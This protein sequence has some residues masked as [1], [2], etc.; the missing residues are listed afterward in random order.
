MNASASGECENLTMPAS[1]PYIKLRWY[2]MHGEANF[3][4]HFVKYKVEGNNRNANANTSVQ[5]WAAANLTFSL[6][7]EVG[8]T[9]RSTFLPDVGT[10]INLPLFIFL[11]VY[12]I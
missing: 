7:T 3:T 4:M 11:E 12:L 5:Y 9:G 2:T 8:A 1:Q 6:E 10:G